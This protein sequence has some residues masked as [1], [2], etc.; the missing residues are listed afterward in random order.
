M[1]SS[2]EL[3]TANRPKECDAFLSQFLRRMRSW[4]GVIDG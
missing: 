4:N 1:A 3:V 2:K